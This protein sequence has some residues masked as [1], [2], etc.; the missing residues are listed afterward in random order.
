MT[1]LAMVHGDTPSFDVVVVHPV[2]KDPVDISDA[3]IHMR[4][5]TVYGTTPLAFDV[6]TISGDI[7]PVPEQTNRALIE[8]PASATE[9]LPNEFTRL[10][11]DV[12]VKIGSDEWTTDRGMLIVNPKVAVPAP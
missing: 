12:V 9:T 6:S 10:F 11:F 1:T 4:A 7:T 2:T 5:T 3:E 8:L